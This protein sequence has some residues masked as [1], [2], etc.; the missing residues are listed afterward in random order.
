MKKQLIGAGLFAALWMGLGAEAQAF[1]QMDAAMTTEAPASGNLYAV[2][3][4]SKQAGGSSRI[5]R[6]FQCAGTVY[7]Q[8]SEISEGMSGVENSRPGSGKVYGQKRWFHR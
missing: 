5:S 2:G 7:I 1:N 3:G 8:E 4:L 6:W